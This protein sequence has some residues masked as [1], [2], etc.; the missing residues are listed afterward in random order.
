[1]SDEMTEVEKAVFERKIQ[2]AKDDGIMVDS[3]E[4]LSC[5]RHPDAKFIEKEKEYGEFPKS[6]VKEYFCDECWE[7]FK[8][9]L[10]MTM[11]YECP[12][13]GL[14]YGRI[15]MDHFSSSDA[16]WAQLAGR[17]GFIWTCMICDHVFGKV[18]TGWS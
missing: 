14:V 11:A 17:S 3:V 13:C 18:T 12:T 6:I 15:S 8:I 16:S 2:K 7:E 4:K 1:M 10:F 9:I 5:K